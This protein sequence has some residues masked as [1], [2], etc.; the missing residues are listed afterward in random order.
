MQCPNPDCEDPNQ[1]SVRSLAGE[2]AKYCHKCGTLLESSDYHGQ[3][4]IIQEEQRPNEYVEPC[5]QETM[6]GKT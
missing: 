2:R 4:D 6:Q 5:S 3:A 1:A